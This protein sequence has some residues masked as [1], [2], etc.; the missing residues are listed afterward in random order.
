MSTEEPE[1]RS[2]VRASFFKKGSGYVPAKWGMPPISPDFIFEGR[3]ND[4]K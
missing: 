1:L 3:R 2:V 4:E